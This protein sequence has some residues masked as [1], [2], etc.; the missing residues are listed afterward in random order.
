M[1]VAKV[2][3]GKEKPDRIYAYGDGA[4]DKPMLELADEGYR[5]AGDRFCIMSK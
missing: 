4:A 5:L 1:P 2:G 3:L